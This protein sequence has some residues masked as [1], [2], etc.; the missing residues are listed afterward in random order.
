M[1]RIV[2]TVIMMISVSLL[3]SHPASDLKAEFNPETATLS[4]EF[5]HNVG[6]P[7]SHSLYQRNS[8]LS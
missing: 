5:T 2:V 7:Q 3:F 1:K 6:D 4:L 8:C